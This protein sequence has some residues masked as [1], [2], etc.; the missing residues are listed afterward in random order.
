MKLK[1]YSKVHFPKIKSSIS[2]TKIYRFLLYFSTSFKREINVSCH[3]TPL[4]FEKNP[5]ARKYLR[6]VTTDPLPWSWRVSYSSPIS[7]CPLSR[8]I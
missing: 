1:M 6:K 4:P 8:G 3:S 2:S 5:I 7:S